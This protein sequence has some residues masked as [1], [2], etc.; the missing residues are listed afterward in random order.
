MPGTTRN[1]A[2]E[3]LQQMAVKH[4]LERKGSTNALGLTITNIV[5]RITRNVNTSL[6]CRFNLFR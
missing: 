4:K 1:H 2:M 5:E 3:L 6:S